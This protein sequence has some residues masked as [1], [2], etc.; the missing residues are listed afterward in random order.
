MPKLNRR[1]PETL[2]SSIGGLLIVSRVDDLLELSMLAALAGDTSQPPQTS[3][4]LASSARGRRQ[5]NLRRSRCA[6]FNPFA[7]ALRKHALDLL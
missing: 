6:G 3:A 5:A 2:L 1:Y 7:N 4:A